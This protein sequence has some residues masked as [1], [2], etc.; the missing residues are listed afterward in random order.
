[1]DRSYRMR[2]G[3]NWH[4]HLDHLRG[5]CQ[6]SIQKPHASVTRCVMVTI[7]LNEKHYNPQSLPHK[8]DKWNCKYRLPFLRKVEVNQCF[9]IM[10]KMDKIQGFV[11]ALTYL[12]FRWWLQL[13]DFLLYIFMM[14]TERMVWQNRSNNITCSQRR[15]DVSRLTG[16][17]C[18]IL[19][20]GRR[21]GWGFVSETV[22]NP[23]FSCA[24]W[25][26]HSAVKPILMLMWT[27]EQLPSPN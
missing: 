4:M 18:L 8:Q 3:N 12:Q 22:L 21:G 25:L 10:S 27:A 17:Y 7:L 23:S 14:K 1:M 19:E 5:Q 2:D 13:P 11:L 6:D 16:M 20:W 26:N 15:D 9:Q 24:E